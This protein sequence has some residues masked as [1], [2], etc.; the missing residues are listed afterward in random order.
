M[1]DDMSQSKLVCLLSRELQ[2]RE[3]LETDLGQVGWVPNTFPLNP[4]APE[5]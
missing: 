2:I 1:Y 5:P 3:S 4:L